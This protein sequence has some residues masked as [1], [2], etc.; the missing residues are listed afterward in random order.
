[1]FLKE[2]TTSEQEHAE[3]LKRGLDLFKGVPHSEN[4]NGFKSYLFKLG[5]VSGEIAPNDFPFTLESE[6]H[7]V[8]LDTKHNVKNY[9]VEIDGKHSYHINYFEKDLHLEIVVSYN[10]VTK[11]VNQVLVMNE[12]LSRRVK[13]IGNNKE[14]LKSLMDNADRAMVNVVEQVAIMI[15]CLNEGYHLAHPYPKHFKRYTGKGFKN[16]GE[17]NL[18]TTRHNN[19]LYVCDAYPLFFE[20]DWQE[21]NKKK[22]ESEKESNNSQE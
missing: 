9:T 18:V 15:A 5:D 20:I 1:M 13:V 4:L 6:A 22:V 10:E 17:V 14:K 21:M 7:F 2:L 8:L 19:M 3:A 12:F 16:V 11:E